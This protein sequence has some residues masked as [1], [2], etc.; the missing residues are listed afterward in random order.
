M[1]EVKAPVLEETV[2]RR[3]TPYGG[4]NLSLIHIFIKNTGIEQEIAYFRSPPSITR[5]RLILL[6]SKIGFLRQKI[7]FGQDC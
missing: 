6:K 3:N 1:P 4:V 7:K 5:Q 2:E